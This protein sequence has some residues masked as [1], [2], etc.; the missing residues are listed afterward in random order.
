MH[1]IYHSKCVTPASIKTGILLFGYL[2]VYTCISFISRLIYNIS[3]AETKFV[4]RDWR[5]FGLGGS[6]NGYDGRK[7]WLFS[8]R[9]CYCGG[10]AVIHWSVSPE[11]GPDKCER[12]HQIHETA[13]IWVKVHSGPHS[14]FLPIDEDTSRKKHYSDRLIASILTQQRLTIAFIL[15]HTHTHTHRLVCACVSLCHGVAECENIMRVE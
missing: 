15:T 12:L 11:Q 9:I 8:I 5:G 1:L 14:R 7:I 2:F 6:S 3:F 4:A 10:K 13:G